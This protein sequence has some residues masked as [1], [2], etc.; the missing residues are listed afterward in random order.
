MV[1]I[2]VFSIL[3]LLSLLWTY[4]KKTFVGAVLTY[5]FLWALLAS[6]VN[7]SMQQTQEKEQ[8][9]NVG[10]NLFFKK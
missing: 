4:K 2:F 7:N 5:V 8:T 9:V 1:A 3:F 10:E 6:M